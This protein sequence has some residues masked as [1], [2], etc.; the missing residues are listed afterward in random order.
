[1]NLLIIPTLQSCSFIFFTEST[2]LEHIS[3]DKS[4]T[5]SESIMLSKH[6]KQTQNIYFISGPASFTTLRN[7]SVFLETLKN[8]SEY[9]PSENK[10]YNFFNISTQE[11]LENYT[12]NTLSNTDNLHLYSVGRREVFI[13]KNKNQNKCEKIKNKDLAQYIT[14]NTNITCSGFLS[15]NVITILKQNN[16]EYIN[17]EDDL[18]KNI[19]ITKILSKESTVKHSKDIFIDYGSLPTIG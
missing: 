9:S 11:F 15:E 18:E 4:K 7:M 14:N 17:L 6:W 19:N 3:L 2:I 16:I 5:F 10:I 12:I 13:F 1:M 8:F